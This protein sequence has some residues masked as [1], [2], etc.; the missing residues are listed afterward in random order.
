[1]MSDRQE[2][3]IFRHLW[4]DLISEQQVSPVKSPKGFVL[5]GQPGAG[6]SNLVG[7]IRQELNRN[8][9][10]INGDEFRRYHPNFDG[11]Q[12]Q[13]GIDSPKHTAAFS[14]HMTERV[15]EKALR[16]GY[17][18][19]VEG[20]FRTTETPMR[21]L[22]KMREHGYE[23][24]VYIQT[25]PSEVSWQSTLERYQVMELLGETPRATPKE[26]HDLVVKLLPQNA[27]TVFLSGKAD[28]FKVFSREGLIFDSRIYKGQ[29]PSIIIDQELH[30]NTRRLEM[31]ESRIKQ[32]SDVL[33]DFQKKVIYEAEKLIAGLQ[34]ADQVHAKI[35][36]YDSQLQQIERQILNA[37]IGFDR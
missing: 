15:I 22:E 2:A 18:I 4:N 13:Y 7:I 28:V 33:S 19:S 8:V 27:D 35:N 11:I 30:R 16:E 9:L 29:I 31:L 24:A 21:T 37:D 26:H 5:G 3:L 23:T 34:P 1:M 17:N 14:G 32:E 12:E 10:I 36:L 20:T 6:K 25:A